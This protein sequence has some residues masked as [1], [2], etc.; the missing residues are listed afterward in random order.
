MTAY[1]NLKLVDAFTFAREHFE[2]VVEELQAPD[3]LMMQH[4]DIEDIVDAG[5]REVARR[6][7]QGHL[8][9][10]AAREHV[11]PAV[12]GS[13]GVMR[14]H[15]RKLDRRLC[16]IFGS[17]DVTRMGYGARKHA[18]LCPLDAELNLP[19][20]RYSH[21][22]RKRAVLEA[23]RGS[24]E[25]AV[26]AIERNVAVHVPKR[27]LEELVKRA[28]EDFEAFYE[29]RGKSPTETTWKHLLCLSLDSKGIVMRKEGLTDETRQ[30]ADDEE[31]KLRRRLSKGEK[32]NRKRMATVAAVWDVE[33]HKREPDDIMNDLRPVRRKRK[34][35][36]VRNKRVWARINKSA[37]GV[38][39]EVFAEALRRDP[40][41]KRIWV[42]LVDG[43]NHQINRVKRHAKI[44][45]EHV[46][47]VVDFIHVLEY[48]WKAA[49][50]FFDEGDAQAERWVVERA[51]HILHGRS[52]DVAAGIRRSATLRGLD[53]KQ[54]KGADDCANYLLNK[55]PYLQYDHFLALGM[56]IA[57]GVIEGACRHL[58]ND[59]MAVTGARWGLTGAE[60]VLRLRS[61]RSSAD[62]D[63]YWAFHLTRERERT[64]TSRY[65]DMPMAA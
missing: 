41:R 45:D 13:D 7:V 6:L 33:R 2:S 44:H 63:E 62:F 19:K 49:W 10:R 57:T 25:T 53:D 39:D 5:M 21:G 22:L 46:F 17:V 58:V 37:D 34:R 38:T 52:S 32:R 60:A 16:T 65:I 35:P 15:H 20:E 55:R 14:R 36:P 24:F 30:A 47:I 23:T 64:H 1:P 54:R 26:D 56:P 59:R 31:H 8:D 42:V 4:G 9:L 11:A 61:L 18:S 43:D 28:A 48:L 3:A 29:D 40:E 50:S 12:K 27:Q 51:R